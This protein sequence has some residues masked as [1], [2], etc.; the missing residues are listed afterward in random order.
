VDRSQ[1]FQI[2]LLI[3]GGNGQLAKAI[4]KKLLEG[5]INFQSP[6]KHKLDITN[7][8]NL[9]F[10]VK[11]IK[12]EIIVNCAA[13][14]DV[15]GC[16]ANS[17]SAFRINSDAVS[18][19]ATKCA[20]EGIKLIHISSDYV[21]SGEKDLPWKTN[22]PTFPKTIYG[23]SKKRAEKYINQ[24]ED[25]DFLIVRS[26]WI[27]SQWGV[28]FPK[29]IV[30]SILSGKRE[31]KVVSDQIGQPT[32]A[33]DLAATIVNLMEKKV[34]KR[35][36]HASNFGSTS[37][38][39]FAKLISSKFKGIDIEIEPILTSM[40]NNP[41]FRPKYSALDCSELEEVGIDLLPIWSESFSMEFE[42]IL[43]QSEKEL[44][45]Q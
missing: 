27:Y 2:M 5:K 43:N 37:W 45:A 44:Y 16:E 28:N 33:N 31:F 15:D 19:L 29:K 14:T 20:T 13:W 32:N 6:G 39:D 11:E 10:M 17:S 3:T 35:I 26:S 21:F 23:E 12:P 1:V 7:Y 8:S 25:L 4:S 42:N 36:L 22:D 38:Y 34:S 40:L 30:K 9:D 24:C 18:N 41:I